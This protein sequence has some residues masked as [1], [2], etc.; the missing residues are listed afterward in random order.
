MAA[1]MPKIDAAVVG[2]QHSADAQRTLVMAASA[3]SAPSQSARTIWSGQHLF[4]AEEAAEWLGGISRT[5]VYGLL[6]SGD[7]WPI[8]IGRAMRIPIEALE[9]YRAR[10][11]AEG[12]AYRSLEVEPRRL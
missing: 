6:S 4:T 8:H 10:R 11:I 1:S 12:R 2:Q 7:L 9:E 3:A 5:T